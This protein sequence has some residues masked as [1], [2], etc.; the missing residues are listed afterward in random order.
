MTTMDT[1][2]F[3]ARIE[4]EFANFRI[5]HPR[6]V[7][8]GKRLDE[9]RNVAEASR[10]EWI[11]RG[12][13]KKRMPMK[14]L[15]VIAPS[16]SGKST[17]VAMY[18]EDV[19][20][21]EAFGKNHRPVVHVTLSSEATTKRLGSDILEEFGDPDP[22]T[23]TAPQLMR[24]TYNALEVAE[25]DVLVI[26]EIQ[27]LIHADTGQRTAWSVTETLKRMLIRGA[28]PLVLMGT[29]EAKSVLLS[30]NQM[31]QRA[32]EPVFLEPLDIQVA[33][34]RTM[35]IEHVAGIDL[36]MVEHG[37]AQEPSGLVVGDLPACFY[38]VSKGVI[39][40]V[41]NL[42][43]VA[44]KHA[45]RDGRRGVTRED[46]SHAT[47]RW[48]IPTGISDHDPFANGARDLKQLKAAA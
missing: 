9:M 5:P 36:K 12:R 29:P 15:P 20:G 43:M 11:A 27:H 21:K 47:R 1:A 42:V 41:S 37:L 35:F 33:E 4:V 16:G 3:V 46:L 28:C 19:V 7:E 13:P 25:T 17:S 48:A 34:E 18:L 23:G 6:L 24:R 32:L 38:D 8:V 30:N 45:A 14:F 44:A 31:K 40:T 39:G 10:A 26:D 2:A 22:E